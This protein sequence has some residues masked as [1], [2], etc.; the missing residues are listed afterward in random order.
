MRCFT[1]QAMSEMYWRKAKRIQGSALAVVLAAMLFPSPAVADGASSQILTQI[2]WPVD[3]FTLEAS[4]GYL[5]HVFG[6]GLISRKAVVYFERPNQRSAASYSVRSKITKKGIWA[7]FGALGRIALRFHPSQ[8]VEH[9]RACGRVYRLRLGTY[10]GEI[11]FDGEE[12]FSAVRAHQVRGD[13]RPA[14]SLLCPGGRQWS[15]PPGAVLDVKRSQPGKPEVGFEAV[16]DSATGPTFLEAGIQERNGGVS[17]LRSVDAMTGP[18]AFTYGLE[19]YTATIAP[20]PPFSGTAYFL[21]ERP[22]G[23]PSKVSG[24]L[25]VDFPGR[26]G[27]ALTGA[28]FRGELQTRGNREVGQLA[29]LAQIWGTRM[30]CIPKCDPEEALH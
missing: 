16:Q 14:L 23:I 20:P 15:G 9:V 29:G 25:R 6:P 8:R 2:P 17:I 22:P 5:V 21:G 4:K 3:A 11:R 30:S 24:D 27:V 26:A 12:G 28:G 7:N 19:K 18:E 13:L 10:V 1:P